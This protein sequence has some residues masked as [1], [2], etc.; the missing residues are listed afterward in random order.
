M[1]RRRF[2]MPTRGRRA[3]SRSAAEVR[4]LF[5]TSNGT[6]LGHLARAMAIARRLPGDVEPVIFTLSAAAPVV[7]QMGLQ[8]EY[9]PSYRMPASGSDWQWNMRLRHRLEELIDELKPEA[10]VFDGVH[11]YRALTHVLTARPDLPAIWI[12]R[13]MWRPGKGKAALSRSG[14]FNVVLEPGEL[15]S[16]ED[17][18]GTVARSDEAI[19]VDPITYLDREEMLDRQSA[20]R[21]LE[22]DPGQV[23]ALVALGQGAGLEATVARS[24]KRLSAAEGVRVVALESS[25]AGGLEIPPGVVHL[26]SRFP[27]ARYYRAFDFAVSAAGY[28]AFHELLAA[29][30]PTL[31]VPMRRQSDDQAARARWAQESGSGLGVDSADS[32]QLEQRLDELLLPQRRAALTTAAEALASENGAAEAA[33]AVAGLV[34][35]G[36]RARPNPL[37]RWITYS[38]HPV[39]PSL[40]IAAALLYRQLRARPEL[41][42]PR[43]AVLALGVA[44]LSASELISALSEAFAELREEHGRI[45]VLTDSL[46]FRALRELGC[47]FEYIPGPAEVERVADAGYERF[48]RRRLVELLRGRR[49]RRAVSVDPAHSELAAAI[50]ASPR[51]RRRLLV[52]SG[53]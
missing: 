35:G 15:A 50:E 6:G 52:T 38:A 34:G 41:G 19:A 12:R 4:I 11:P 14:A 32:P 45:L 23:N 3:E 5:T 28:N 33:R 27:L 1:L 46:E 36:P 42:K 48:L 16:A 51:R 31:F 49:P 13:P 18:G 26:R 37:R 9:L 30:V 47:G 2:W 17:R 43:A 40:P 21:E 10:L 24:L 53:S 44:E 22:L 25:L 7:A 8:V 39:G 29:G 20:A